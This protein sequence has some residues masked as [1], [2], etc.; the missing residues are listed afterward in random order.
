MRIRLISDIID[1]GGILTRWKDT[2]WGETLITRKGIFYNGDIIPIDTF[3]CRIEQAELKN[4]YLL[5]R[6]SVP[7]KSQRIHT[8][9]EIEVP[10]GFEDPVRSFIRIVDTA[11][12]LKEQA[13]KSLWMDPDDDDDFN[14]DRYE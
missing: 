8:I 7:R 11:S 1:A 6:Y 9:L 5:I 4:D 3:N 2:D 13:A 10:S 12:G 14:N